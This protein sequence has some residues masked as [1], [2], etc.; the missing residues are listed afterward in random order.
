VRAKIIL[1]L[2]AAVLYAFFLML[3]AHDLWTVF[4]RP[5]EWQHVFGLE[6]F[7]WAYKARANYII[8]D[9]ALLLWHLLGLALVLLSLG[10][11]RFRFL[12]AHLVLTFAYLAWI[13]AGLP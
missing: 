9:I 11:R 1:C 13:R 4:Y 6:G 12:A 8:S 3:M 2:L 10:K 7:G 5:E